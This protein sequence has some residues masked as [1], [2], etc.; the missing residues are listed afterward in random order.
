MIKNVPQLLSVIPKYFVSSIVFG[1]LLVSTSAQYD[2]YWSDSVINSY[3]TE[4]NA[5][6][7]SQII[8]GDS[9]L[10]LFEKRD[11]PCNWI[12]IGIR[13]SHY[14]SAARDDNG[15]LSTVNN[16]FNKYQSGICKED[17]LLPEIYL[18]Y[19]R[20]YMN[21]ELSNKAF[22]YIHKGFESW[23]D[24]FPNKTVLM[25]L[26]L[27]KGFLFDNLDST[28]HY[29]SLA[30]EL[31]VNEDDLK[32]QQG[33]LNDLGYAYAVRGIYTEAET[34]FRKALKVAQKREAYIQVSSIFNNIAGVSENNQQTAFYLDSAFYYASLKGNLNAMQMAKQNSAL[35]HYSNDSFQRGYD[36]LWQSMLIKDSL[37]NNQKI[38][39]FAEMEQK[40]QSELKEQR[41]LYLDT[42]NKNRTRQRNGLIG[43]FFLVMVFAVSV[44]FQRNRIAKERK[45]S[46]LLLR[47]ILP[48]EIAEELKETG[49][50]R[51][52]DFKKV[53]VMFTDFV[54]FTQQSAKLSAAE[55]VYE[56]NHCFE[57]FD[58]IIEKYNIEKI[59]T[60]GDSYMAA[61]GLPIPT[62]VSVKNTVQAALEM[63]A[64]IIQHKTEMDAAGK[65]AFEMRV[66]I[67]TGPVVAG[68][69][70]IKK[71]QYDI[72]GDT[73]N[74]A[75]RM[76]NHGE[77]G[78]VNISKA[79]YELL[80]GDPQF[81]F[82]S[83][84]KIEAKGKGEIEMWFVSYKT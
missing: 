57:A 22:A 16:V 35:F 29:L 49:R 82:E 46:D 66:G 25:E 59:K 1:L 34:Y 74:T 32:H 69:V 76:E 62:N 70:G 21:M 39:A 43:G 8:V 58:Y 83:R 48:Q 36:E 26:Y 12:E 38:R 44:V 31:A 15:A 81:T 10:L 11:E 73:V 3:K 41:I 20:T 65:P 50:A 9:L 75:S 40:F 17:H 51:A 77:I 60:I 79:T 23:N 6:F 45:R 72:W 13:K 5:N 52:Q 80:K 53:S 28:V 56:I 30:Y 63:Q 33:A 67:H 42:Q 4:E 47:N 7:K 64:F 19:A 37:Y 71:F 24:R 14:Q 61:G 54:E 18:A 55:L 2:S 84:G 68:I 27:S 78:K